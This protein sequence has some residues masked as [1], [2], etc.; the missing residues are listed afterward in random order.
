MAAVK[1]VLIVG[2]G[3][4]GLAAAIALRERGI[5]V[6]V[7][8]LETRV[9]GLGITLTGTT[10]RALDMVGL[11][12]ESVEKGFGFDFFLV[13][14]GA[15]NLQAKNPL[16]PAGAGL[17]AAVGIKRPLFADIMTKA[18]EAK[19]ASIR[20]GLTVDAIDQDDADVA[21]RFTDGSG[22]RYDLVV[23]ADGVFSSIRKRVFGEAYEPTYVG[24]G[25]YRFMTERHPSIDQIHVFVGPKLKAGFIPLSDDSMYLF[26]TMSY[27][28]HTRIDES[29]THLIL[30]EA[31]KDFTAP[32]VVEVRERMRSPEKVIWRPFENTLVPSPWYRGRVVLIGDAAHT[33]TPHLTA[34]G[35]MAIEDAVILAEALAQDLTVSATLDNFMTRRFERVRAAC[36]ISLEICK[37]EQAAE[38]D[39]AKIYS[40]TGQG[41]A[42]LGKSF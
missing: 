40:L 1:R 12:A 27:P 17:P 33:M 39:V 16:P 34:G 14:D 22:G 31:L 28:P 4:G 8:E 42:L 24:Q 19:G 18:A 29:K 32:I 3:I 11:A 35:G 10:L 21:V 9:L 13:S 30:K 6:D 20:Y 5:T 15:G 7:V 38:P 37:L 36:D 26:T 2:A 41:Y 23:G 25:V